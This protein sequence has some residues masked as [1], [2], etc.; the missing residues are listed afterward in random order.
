M[1]TYFAYGSNLSFTQMQ[2]RCPEHRVIGLGRLEHHRWTISG[3]PNAA[4]RGAANIVSSP[5]DHVLGTVFAISPRDEAALDQS[6]GVAPGAYLKVQVV[7]DIG[8][9]A[10][11][12]LTY[13][14]P[15]QR[16]E[17][18]RP[19]YKARVL[20]G[21]ADAKLPAAYINKYLLPQLEER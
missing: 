19:G 15:Q 17:A 3:S 12:C 21:A 6:E 20:A 9:E 11:E 18:A 16:D 13:V 7:I 10:V 14:R 1:T 2:D 4:G 8:G 5:A